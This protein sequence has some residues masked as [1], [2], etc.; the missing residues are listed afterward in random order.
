MTIV[1]HL[2]SP[3]LSTAIRDLIARGAP[4]HRAVL[5]PAGAGRGAQQADVILVDCVTLDSRPVRL[6]DRAKIVLFNIGLRRERLLALLRTHRVAGVISCQV[7]FA[8]FRKALKVIS[9]GQ[10]WM[11]ND[12][13]RDLLDAAGAETYV[14]GIGR[15]T[16]REHQVVTLVCGGMS[17]RM[18]AGELCVSEQTVKGYLN[19]IFKRCGVASRAQLI[20]L[21]LGPGL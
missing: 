20:S 7:D 11:E 21:M 10:I 12:L 17:N 14:P 5:M 19:G 2:S 16:A 3:L 18:I 13:V 4:E 1:V 8:L 9:D 6:Q 15:L